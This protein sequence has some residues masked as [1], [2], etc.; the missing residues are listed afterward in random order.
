M[1]LLSTLA[2][3]IIH[4]PKSVPRNIKSSAQAATKK[5]T[6]APSKPAPE[7]V[8]EEKSDSGEK[9]QK[10]KKAGLSN[11]DFAKLFS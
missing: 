9:S 3:A 6:S 5:A 10:P 11:A 4:P 7:P 1:A 8:S 2:R